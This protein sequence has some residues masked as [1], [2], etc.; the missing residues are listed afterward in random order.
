MLDVLETWCCRW[1]LCTPLTA[2]CTYVSILKKLAVTDTP[3]NVQK[4]KSFLLWPYIQEE[5]GKSPGSHRNT[6]EKASERTISH[7]IDKSN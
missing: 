3:H 7:K 1:N 4:K 6:R 2:R 5:F